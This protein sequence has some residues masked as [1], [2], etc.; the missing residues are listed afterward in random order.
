MLV[1][2]GVDRS[3]IYTETDYYS[4][5]DLDM[6]DL[7]GIPEGEILRMERISDLIYF[8]EKNQI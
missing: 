2:Y 3:R 6:L 1:D 5:L 7:I 4:D 8:L